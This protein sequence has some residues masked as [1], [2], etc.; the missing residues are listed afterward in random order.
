[1]SEKHTSLVYQ[2]CNWDEIYFLAFVAGIFV[3]FSH[4][5]SKENVVLFE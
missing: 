3:G 5:N 4:Q 1:V 2:T